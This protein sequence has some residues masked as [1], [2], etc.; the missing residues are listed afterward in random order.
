MKSHWANLESAI[1]DVQLLGSPY[2]VSLARQFAYGMAKDKNA[3]LNELI[4]DLRQSLRTELELE[5]VSEPL[6]TFESVAEPQ[7]RMPGS[8]CLRREPGL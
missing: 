7:G 4:S 3:S 6:L 5:A 1:A 2:Q 8:R